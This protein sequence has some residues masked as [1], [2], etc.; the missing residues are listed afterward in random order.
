MK[1][2][3]NYYQYSDAGEFSIR[4]DQGDDFAKKIASDYNPIHNADSK[5]FCVPGDLLFAIALQEYGLHQNMEFTF[6]DLVSADTLLKYPN[7]STGVNHELTVVC[8]REKPVLKVQYSGD[9]INNES[10]IEQLLRSY[11]AF[12][13]QNFPHILT[14]LMQEHGVMINPKRPLVIYQ[15]MSLSFTSLTFSELNIELSKSSL[16]V[17]GKRGQ[18]LLKFTLN[19]GEKEVGVGGKKLVLSGLREYKQDAIDGLV[20]D[21]LRAKELVEQNLNN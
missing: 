20:D 12:S 1:F 5:R 7:I 18:V 9:A 17:D 2:L 21:Y 15:S 19:D 4:A 3:E 11:V 10:S 16:S 14:P 6:L 13:G 8:A